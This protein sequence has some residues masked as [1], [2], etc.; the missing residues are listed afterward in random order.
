MATTRNAGAPLFTTSGPVAEEEG[1]LEFDIEF[2]IANPCGSIAM[3]SAGWRVWRFNQCSRFPIP[4][5]S[6]QYYLPIRLDIHDLKAR[7]AHCVVKSF[8]PEVG[9]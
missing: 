5:S 6:Y 4:S 3:V 2:D 7:E 9:K 1:A 8:E